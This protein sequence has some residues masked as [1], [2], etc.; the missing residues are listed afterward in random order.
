VRAHHER[1]APGS[2]LAIV[3]QFDPAIRLR[4]CLPDGGFDL[5]LCD[6]WSSSLLAVLVA[7]SPPERGPPPALTVRRERLLV[8][9]ENREKSG[10]PGH[11]RA[12]PGR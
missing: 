12:L 1:Q 5:A 2:A 3:L 10:F 11:F 6:H 8:T 4:R 9:W 7:V